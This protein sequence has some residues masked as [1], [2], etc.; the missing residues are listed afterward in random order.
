MHTVVFLL[1]LIFPGV[2]FA[3][4]SA[5]PDWEMLI[6]QQGA[7]K[8]YVQLGI[9]TA[10]DDT[11]EQHDEAHR[12][13]GALYTRAGLEGFSVCDE[14]FSY[15][16]FHEFIGRAIAQHGPSVVA[17][18]NERCLQTPD[19]LKC[20]HGVG[21]GLISWAGYEE[22][23]LM[24]ALEQCATLERSD[25]IGGCP[26]GVF[27]EYDLRTM[28][29]AEGEVRPGSRGDL[30]DVCARVPNAFKNACAYWRPQWWHELFFDGSRT[31]ATY[32]TLGSLC[33]AF[34][35]ERG[36]YRA[37]IEGF[38]TT[39]PHFMSDPRTDT[40][41]CSVIPRSSGGRTACV[42]QIFRNSTAGSQC[43]LANSE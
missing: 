39:F 42:T 43:R 22:K 17:S 35:K 7:E 6:E 25:P 11:N 12:F 30:A 31:P 19:F 24:Q 36:N 41:L 29:G 23:N 27:M 16:C 38:V 34:E 2:L 15:G 14:Q 13:G 5:V 18:L 10:H 4:E 21:H 32:R 9:F 26:G 8:A 1:T 20:Q 33:D 37:C 3:V 40:P 28:L